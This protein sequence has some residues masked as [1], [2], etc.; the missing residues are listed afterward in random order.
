MSENITLFAYL[1]IEHPMVAWEV[2]IG[3]IKSSCDKSPDNFGISLWQYS[4][5]SNYCKSGLGHRFINELKLEET[6]QRDFP[7]QVSRLKGAYFFET[8]EDAQIA[9]ERWGIPQRK[10]YISAVNFSAN[11]ITRLDSEWIT[12]YL[13]SEETDWMQ[14]YWKGITLGVRPLTEVLASGIGIVQNMELRTQAYKIIMERWPTSTPLLAFACCA[15][16]YKKMEEIGL[17]KPAILAEEGSVIGTYFINMNDLDHREAE[18]AEVVAVC[19]QNQELPPFI[20][21]DDGKSFFLIPDLREFRFKLVSGE[22]AQLYRSVHDG[23]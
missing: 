3:R 10:K 21:P 22:A 17:V 1:N 2:A 19:K 16:K 23:R 20:I 7:N 14:E 15:F 4:L 6:R 12:S 11:A 5:L 18:V 13:C 8:I 9:V